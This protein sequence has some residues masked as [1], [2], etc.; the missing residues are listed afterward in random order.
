M[1]VSANPGE[2]KHE[3][4]FKELQRHNGLR[5]TLQW[6]AAVENY[7]ILKNMAGL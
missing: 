1:P 2:D 6:E 4:V 3:T 5:A 7:S